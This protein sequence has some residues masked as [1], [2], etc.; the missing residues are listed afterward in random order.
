LASTIRFTQADLQL[1]SDVSGDRSPLHI[2]ESYAARTAYG[3]VLVFGVQ[4]AIACLGQMK[5]GG[6][7]LKTFDAEFRRPFFRGI[8]YRVEVAEQGGKYVG[9]IFD[10]TVQVLTTTVTLADADYEQPFPV[11]GSGP[12]RSVSPQR[13]ASEIAPGT[14]VSGSYSCRRDLLPELAARWGTG[15]A[16]DQ[17]EMLVFCSYVSGMELPGESSLSFRVTVNFSGEPAPAY[18]GFQFESTVRSVNAK[19]G[20]MRAALEFEAEGAPLG[21]GELQAFIRPTPRAADE[22]IVRDRSLEGRVVAITGTTRGLGAALAAVFE[23][24]G[25]SVIGISRTALQNP[26]DASDPRAVRELRERIL[27]RHGRLDVLICNAAP[28]LVPLRLEPNAQER[29]DEYIRQA[30]A[31]ALSPI[32]GL[33][34]LLAESQGTL[35]AISA[36]AAVQPDREFPHFSAA[37]AALEALVQAAVLQHAKVRGLIVRPEKLLTGMAGT[38]LG[39]IGAVSPAELASRIGDRCAAATLKQGAAEVFS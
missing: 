28:P 39:R 38:P 1:F 10:G 19:L 20:H 37:K 26:G 30:T 7:R 32:C 13:E 35:I 8:E 5:P 31:L 18:A 2:S 4:G 23:G 14:R 27:E 22:A 15:I 21:S 34:D 16:L 3:Q 11:P 6:K 33:I 12:E 9:R 24:R 25:A 17:L 29:I 36:A